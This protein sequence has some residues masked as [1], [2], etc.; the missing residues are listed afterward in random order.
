KP[1]EDTPRRTTI[2]F[3]AWKYQSSEQLWSGL[4]HAIL[5]QVGDRMTPL[6]RDRLWASMQVRRVRLPELRRG[7]YRYIALRALPYLPVTPVAVVCVVVV[8]LVDAD[9][10][11]NVSIGAAILAVISGGVGLF[12]SASDEVTK[13]TPH[14]VEEP[15]Y[16]SKLGFLHLVDSDMRRILD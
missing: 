5:S 12:R 6:D 14:L 11:G 4:A 8:W 15:N 3:N 1:S 16:E 7:F 10:L 9:V 2:W 13:A